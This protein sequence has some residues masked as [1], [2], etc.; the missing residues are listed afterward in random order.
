MLAPLALVV[1][2]I[3]GV[4]TAVV[5][6]EQGGGASADVLTKPA[7]TQP[8]PAPREPVNPFLE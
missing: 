1:L 5:S 8:R 6:Q 4:Q 7:V 3:G 2:L